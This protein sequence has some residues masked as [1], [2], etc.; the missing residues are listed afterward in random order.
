[1]NKTASQ[2]QAQKAADHH[3][4]LNAFGAVIAILEGG[5][6]YDPGSDRAALRII[7]I[8]KAEMQSQLRKFDKALSKI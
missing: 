7:E 5:T 8:A 4:T 2:K 1:M 3:S 6:L